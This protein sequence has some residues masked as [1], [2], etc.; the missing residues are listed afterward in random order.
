MGAPAGA[1]AGAA[2]GGAREA[3]PREALPREALPKAA[4]AK[5]ALA[6]EILPSRASRE[7]QPGGGAGAPVGP[8]ETAW[9]ALCAMLVALWRLCARLLSPSAGVKV[10][11]A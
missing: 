7:G 9:A 3:L 8:L 11:A 4:L 2:A 6:T 1:S 10:K 5:G